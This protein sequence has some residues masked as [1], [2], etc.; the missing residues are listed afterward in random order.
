MW[1]ALYCNVLLLCMPSTLHTHAHSTTPS[2]RKKEFIYTKKRQ[3]EVVT[4]RN[5]HACGTSQSPYSH[6]LAQ[7]DLAGKSQGPRLMYVAM[8]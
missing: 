4:G 5:P 2:K 3:V 6:G 8:L 7:V 1:T